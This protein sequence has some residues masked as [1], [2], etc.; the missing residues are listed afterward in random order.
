[1]LNVGLALGHLGA[2]STTVALEI[3]TATIWFAAVL[4]RTKSIV[5]DKNLYDIFSIYLGLFY[6]IF[7]SFQDQKHANT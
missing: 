6:V 5:D 3:E 4:A 1:V 7:S 2:T